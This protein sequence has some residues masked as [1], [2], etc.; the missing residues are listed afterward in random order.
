MPRDWANADDSVRTTAAEAASNFVPN[1]IR[2]SFER[3]RIC[4]HVHRAD[5]IQPLP[6]T[7]VQS[8]L[9]NAVPIGDRYY[10]K[11]NFVKDLAPAL[12]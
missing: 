9:D 2:I 8:M 4:V 7:A 5:L 6:Y 3:D 1:L 11:S 12:P 10:W